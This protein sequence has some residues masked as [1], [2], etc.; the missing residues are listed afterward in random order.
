MSELAEITYEPYEQF[1]RLVAHDGLVSVGVNEVVATTTASVEAHVSQFNVIGNERIHTEV[2]VGYRRIGD[3]WFW[4]A[5]GITNG[6]N[7]QIASV[8]HRVAAQ[9]VANITNRSVVHH[10]AIKEATS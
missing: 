6:S 8:T 1:A 4:A 2:T 5:S 9:A 3:Q 7:Q 10:G